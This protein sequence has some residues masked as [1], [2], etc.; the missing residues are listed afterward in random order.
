MPCGK[1]HGGGLSAAPSRRRIGSLIVNN[2]WM[3]AAAGL[4]ALGAGMLMAADPASKPA[5]KPGVAATVGTTVIATER[6]DE[7]VSKRELPPDVDPHIRKQLRPRLMAGLIHA[8]LVHA[9]IEDNKITCEQ[10]DIDKV[11]ADLEKQA[12]AQK[13]TL[14]QA[15]NANGMT[16][17][18]LIDL[19]RLQKLLEG[20][21]TQE[22]VDGFI[23]AHPKYFDGTKV[24]ASHVLIKC[25]PVASTAEQQAALK[26]IQELAEE[27]KANKLTFAMA[28]TLHSAC[29]SKAQGGDLGEFDF[30]KMVPSFAQAA[31]DLP[32]G[33]TTIARSDYGYH[34][35]KVTGRVDGKVP[36]KAEAAAQHA[37]VVIQT[38]LQA[39]ILA[40][41]LTTCPIVVNE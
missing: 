33:G 12:A 35:I 16:M 3:Y 30:D 20:M 25:S 13:M 15:M 8:A 39:A 22:K 18:Q 36:M 27:V 4:V 38:N 9:Y 26:K 2:R 34:L 21:T 10:K 19:I 17:P 14:E 6:L 7:L 41:A 37:K 29:P 31:F 11:K 40:Q 24:K 28:A 1:I 5:S 23:K 32:V